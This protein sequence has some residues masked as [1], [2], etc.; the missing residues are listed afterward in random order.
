MTL[1]CNAVIQV[2]QLVSAL[3]M[4]IFGSAGLQIRRNGALGAKARPAAGHEK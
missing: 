4:L 2:H 3:Q 1:I